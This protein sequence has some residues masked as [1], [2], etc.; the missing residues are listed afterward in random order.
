MPNPT[1]KIRGLVTGLDVIATPGTPVRALAFIGLNTQVE[2]EVDIIATALGHAT[3]SGMDVDVEYTPGPPNT[4]HRLEY[5]PRPE[6]LPPLETT[7]GGLIT[8][9]ALQ[10]AG[11][12]AYTSATIEYHPGEVIEVESAIPM[13][14][15]ALQ[16]ATRNLVRLEIDYISGTKNTLTRVRLLDR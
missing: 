15:A 3:R 7:E 2:T 5:I 13:I 4:I 9:L 10:D 12:S 6:P 16:A 1:T 11:R 8:Q 14:E